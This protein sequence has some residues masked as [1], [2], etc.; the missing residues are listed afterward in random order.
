MCFMLGVVRAGPNLRS[1]IWLKALAV[2][3]NMD[4]RYDG[5]NPLKLNNLGR[6]PA[7]L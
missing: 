5:Q 2:S 7:V 3:N 4:H 6:L 1:T